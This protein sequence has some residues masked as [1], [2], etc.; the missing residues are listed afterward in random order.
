M[1]TTS[2]SEHPAPRKYRRH[3]A[4][5]RVSTPPPQPSRL[6]AKGRPSACLAGE[7]A[8]RPG[9]VASPLLQYFRGTPA[10]IDSQ[11][12]DGQPR[13]GWAALT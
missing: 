7:N 6:E 9:W 1:Q 5:L 10:R 2:P 8:L 11:G 12:K 3:M 4:F 13:P